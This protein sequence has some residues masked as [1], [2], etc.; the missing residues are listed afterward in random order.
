MTTR[1]KIK[2]DVN[3]TDR[4]ELQLKRSFCYQLS[5]KYLAP[6]RRAY[7]ELKFKNPPSV[8]ILANCA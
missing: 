3:I 1:T 6:Q 2:K 8:T 4:P 5:Q 7:N